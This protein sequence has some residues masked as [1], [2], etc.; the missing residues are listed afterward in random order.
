MKKFLRFLFDEATF[1]WKSGVVRLQ[2]H[3]PVV[4]KREISSQI[5]PAKAGVIWYVT[6]PESLSFE[7][8][9]KL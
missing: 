7:L 9:A 6:A 5:T 8:E 2:G 3:I 1:D 4:D